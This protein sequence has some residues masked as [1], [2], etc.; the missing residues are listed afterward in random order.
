MPAIVVIAITLWGLAVTFAAGTGLLQRIW[1]PGIAGL[2]ALGIAVPTAAYFF[3]SGVRAGVRRL[4]LR[5]VT[6]FHI[7]RIP[8]ALLFFW[9]GW[10]GALPPAFW[11]LAG[12]G[13][14]LAGIW[15]VRVTWSANAPLAAYDAMHRF[16][17]ADF[18]VAVGTGFTYALLLDPRMSLLAQLP[19]ALIPFF[20]VG[21]SGATHIMAFDMIRHDGAGRS[22]DTK[23][24]SQGN[25][26]AIAPVMRGGWQ[27]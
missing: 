16:G 26:E 15:A 2:A 4:G 20:G 14:L 19:M 5:S 18:I 3:H 6:A 9:Y 17:F 25:R 1:L 11:V 8:A 7:W 12:T 21:L 27:D 13:D 22:M 10:Q 24:G 23:S